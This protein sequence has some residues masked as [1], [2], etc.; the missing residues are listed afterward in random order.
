MKVGDTVKLKPAMWQGIRPEAYG[1]S[2]AREYVVSTVYEDQEYPS[3]RIEGIAGTF[4]VEAFQLVKE[5]EVSK[6]KVGNKVICTHRVDGN[7]YMIGD[8]L[9]I[10]ACL[11]EVFDNGR[12]YIAYNVAA[13]KDKG[14]WIEESD[15]E[16]V[17]HSKS[18]LDVQ[19]GGSHYK[20]KGIQPVE[21]CYQNNLGF[22]ESNVV[23]YVSR[24]KD[25]NKADDIK[26]AIHYCKFILE[27]EYGIVE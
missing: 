20:D 12:R 22:L 14:V 19:V 10:S 21:Y 16:L 2:F 8:E 4:D 15:F 23:K 5:K 27:F 9:E 7:W 11:G 25:K 18:S 17:K 13:H 26:K 24:H 6:F 3:L 1:L